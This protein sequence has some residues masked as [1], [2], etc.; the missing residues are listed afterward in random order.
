MTATTGE[1]AL[2]PGAPQPRGVIPADTFAARLTLAR[3]HAGNLTLQEAAERC[4][5]IGQSWSNWERGM[6]PRDKADVVEAISSGLGV[7]RDWLMWGGPLAPPPSVRTRRARRERHQDQESVTLPY[8]RVPARGRS[9]P[10]RVIS[11]TDRGGRSDGPCAPG[12][13]PTTGPSGRGDQR[14]PRL[15]PRQVGAQ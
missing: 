4:D 14:R 11:R 15:L 6:V 10:G 3:L 1:R 8:P 5:L 13:T 2:D 9:A 7:D 12:S